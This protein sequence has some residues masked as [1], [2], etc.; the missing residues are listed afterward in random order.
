MKKTIF[1]IFLALMPVLL[2][3]QAN[4]QIVTKKMKLDD[5]TTKTTKVVLPSGTGFYSNI[6]QDE[7]RSKW[8]V[9]PYEFCTTE[10]FESLKGNDEYYFLVTV[11]GKFRKENEPG[12]NLLTLVKGGKTESGSIDD[13]LEI[14]TVPVC[15]V[16]NPNGREAIYLGALLDIIQNHALSSME[17]NISAYG[18]LGA[19]TSKLKDAKDKQ[20][21]IAEEDLSDEFGT[22]LKALFFN[23]DLRCMEADEAD[24]Y[25]LDNTPQT[26]V[27]Y[28]AAP[29]DPQPGSYCYKMLID[30]Q[31]HELYYFKRH[32]ITKKTGAGFLVD[33]IRRI[34]GS[35]K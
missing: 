31:T 27:S 12:L 17:R 2:S 34:T 24:E 16:D 28:V 14:V 15:S 8:R 26:L 6:L 5:F 13:L 21:I 25:M 9:S 11:S 4:I 7:V 23:E 22:S 10:E 32:K 30:A 35:R 20:I 29:S 1:S 18:G 3:A 19:T 33:D